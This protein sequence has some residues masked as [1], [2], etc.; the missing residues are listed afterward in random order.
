MRKMMHL[1]SVMMRNIQ[2][3]RLNLLDSLFSFLTSFGSKSLRSNFNK[4]RYQSEVEV[5]EHYVDPTVTGI[6]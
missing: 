2:P 5:T 1:L 3:C 4:R 6:R